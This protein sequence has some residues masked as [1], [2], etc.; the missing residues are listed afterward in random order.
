MECDTYPV[1]VLAA[2][3][4]RFRYSSRIMD[5]QSELGK[6]FVRNLV[7]SLIHRRILCHDGY[8]GSDSDEGCLWVQ[9]P[10]I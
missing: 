4:R 2:R 10:E 7:R 8:A 5:D 9:K 1:V 3:L 6:H